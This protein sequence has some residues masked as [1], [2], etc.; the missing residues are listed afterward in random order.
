[1]GIPKHLHA[2]MVIKLTVVS[3]C[4]KVT[5]GVMMKTTIVDVIGMGEIVVEEIQIFNHIR[6]HIHIALNAYALIRIIQHLQ[7]Q[8]MKAVMNFL[9]KQ[10]DIVM[11]KTT[12]VDASGMVEIVVVQ[13]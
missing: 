1:M 5:T 12:T 4:G 10:M 6:M 8:M 11:M 3:Q 13:M 2:L 7:G 9:G